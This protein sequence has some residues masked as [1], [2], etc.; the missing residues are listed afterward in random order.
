MCLQKTFCLGISHR[1]LLEQ[2]WWFGLITLSGSSLIWIHFFNFLNRPQKKESSGK[3]SSI[4]AF[5]ISEFL[6]QSPAS[7]SYSYQ[8]FLIEIITKCLTT[9]YNTKVNMLR[10]V[11]LTTSLVSILLHAL[12]QCPSC[13]PFHQNGYV[14][15][16]YVLWFQC[17]GSNGFSLKEGVQQNL[18]LWFRDF[19]HLTLKEAFSHKKGFCSFLRTEI[20]VLSFFPIIVITC[21]LILPGNVCMKIGNWKCKLAVGLTGHTGC[22]NIINSCHLLT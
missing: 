13:Y 7:V 14:I 3:A 12:Q 22:F 15:Q 5:L 20:G 2:C 1:R 19:C 6:D 18:D 8:R 21:F 10:G 17:L 11:K 16:I 9:V 4:K